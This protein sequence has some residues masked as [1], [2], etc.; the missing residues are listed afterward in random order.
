MDESEFRKV[1]D[2]AFPHPYTL[3]EESDYYRLLRAVRQTV[4]EITAR[5]G[6]SVRLSIL[7]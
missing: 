3:M 2:L 7:L 6:K 5:T 1:L 4:L